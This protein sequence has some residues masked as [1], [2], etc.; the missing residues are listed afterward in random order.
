MTIDRPPPLLMGVVNATPDSFSDGGRFP[1]PDHAVRHALALASDGAAILDIGGESTRPGAAPVDAHEELI[2]VLPVVKALAGQTAAVL[3]IDTRKAE[4]AAA[5][6]E[7]GAAI[8]NDVLALT[9]SPDA[10]AVAAGLDC[11]IVLMHARGEPATM[12]DDPRYQDVVEDVYRFLA[13]RIE[14]CVRAGV[15]ES[16]IIVDPGVGFGK[17]LEHNIALLRHVRRVRALGRP[18]LIGASRKRFIAGLDREGPASDRIGGSI[19]A[20]LIAADN[21]ADILRVHDLSA[22]RQALAVARGLV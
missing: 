22:T 14:A 3:S 11:R 6:V 12:Q 8:W 1:D 7:A 19:A 13:E 17:T 20:A 5:A 16:R 2:R 18:V 15:E 9:F 10:L 4:V 21:G